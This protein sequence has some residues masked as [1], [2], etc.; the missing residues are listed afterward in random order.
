MRTEHPNCAAQKVPTQPDSPGRLTARRWP[1]RL[2]RARQ[3]TAC[4]VLDV[5]ALV[6]GAP[7][8]QSLL[9]PFDSVVWHPRS[10]RWAR[11]ARGELAGFLGAP[12]ACWPGQPL[13]CLDRVRTA[14]WAHQL[15]PALA[16]VEG[17]GTRLLVADAVGLGKTL[18]A[19]LVLAELSARGVGTHALV[20]VP[21]GLRDQW[22]DELVRHAGLEA[23]VVDWVALTRR[24]RQ[25]FAGASPWSPPGCAIVSLDFA[26]QPVVLAG[27]ARTF[28]DVLVI[29]EAHAASGDSAR[30]AA[31]LRL[32]RRSR[33]VV[34]LT[35]TPHSGDPRAFRTLT[36]IGAVAGEPMLWF[37]HERGSARP[38]AHRRTRTWS[39]RASGAERAMHDALRRYGNRVERTGRA[40]ARLALVVL[41]KRALSSAAALGRSL[42]HR[43]RLLAD[44]PGAQMLLPLEGPPGETDASDVEQPLLLGAPGYDD[45]GSELHELDHLER[46]AREAA[47][48]PSKWR[49]I[50]RL[51]RATRESVILFT[52][53]RDTLAALA[54]HLSPRFSVAVLHGGLSR[55]ERTA[56]LAT[57]TGGQAR[58]LVATDAA[59][60]GLNLQARCRL[61][62][63]VELPWTPVRLEQRVGRVDRIGQTRTVHEWRL[64]GLDGHETAVTSALARRATAIRTDLA[65]LSG[66]HGLPWAD[67]VPPRSQ[68]RG[69]RVSGPGLSRRAAALAMAAADPGTLA[70]HTGPGRSAAVDR[71]RERPR[72]VRLRRPPAGIGRGVIV[73]FGA[74]PGGAGDV[75]TRV[76]VHVAMSRLPD[77]APTRW[78]PWVVA[79]A[80]PVARA[81]L[82]R[83]DAFVR[84]LMVRERNLRAKERGGGSRRWQPSLFDCRAERILA[85][86]RADSSRLVH[87]SDERLSDLAATRRG[88]PEIEPLLALLVP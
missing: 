53:F 3:G 82:P 88:R 56:V 79:A 20:L 77:E 34:L 33:V 42:E 36:G 74:L 18:T 76:P 80:A 84:A 40:D 50:D 39:L 66:L 11:G 38:G 26:K 5:M 55:E 81:A 68:P 31:V 63:N 15:E 71:T 51:L 24:T 44:A 37:R 9:T 64:A 27:L 72:F 75:V 21:A 22:R 10:R 8:L 2:R 4:Q 30:T 49:T 41:K 59:A 70:H 43:R 54:Q 69:I 58:V 1:W 12:H 29:D 67:R 65:R 87:D 6:R 78:L 83:P 25:V 57:F 85:A 86:T 32:G 46:L 23:D 13:A 28:W 35:A 16:L 17:R 14:P 52:E 62:V 60:E 45:R 7:D 19:A 73:V 48:A 61:V 47:H